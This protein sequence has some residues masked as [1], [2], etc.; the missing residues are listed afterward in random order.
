ME[1]ISIFCTKSIN[2]NTKPDLAIRAD[3]PTVFRQTVLPPV[4]GPVITSTLVFF[5]T[6]KS[7]GTG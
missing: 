1:K 7:S 2:Q 6:K 3:N 5:A 4:L